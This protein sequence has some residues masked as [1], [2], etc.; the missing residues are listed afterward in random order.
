MTIV[1]LKK[2]IW[3]RVEIESTKSKDV[4]RTHPAYMPN[5][6]SQK[7]VLSHFIEPYLISIYLKIR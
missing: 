4:N 3:I 2:N 5:E 1:L 6:V 7:V